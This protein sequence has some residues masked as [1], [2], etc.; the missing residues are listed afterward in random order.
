MLCVK[1]YSQV[2][3]LPIFSLPG[4]S[5]CLK[6]KM[7]QRDYEKTPQWVT[8][9]LVSHASGSF[10]FLDWLQLRPKHLQ[11]SVS[12][13]PF[14]SVETDLHFV[15]FHQ[16]LAFAV[17]FVVTVTKAS[18]N[19]LRILKKNCCTTTLVSKKNHYLVWICEYWCFISYTLLWHT[20]FSSL[21]FTESVFGLPTSCSFPDFLEF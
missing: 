17:T 18:S 5:Q 14:T 6:D 8:V 9:C 19:H 10:S 21:T 16:N 12:F 15:G 4:S 1:W 3:H 11:F 20:G 13:S 2:Q 7:L